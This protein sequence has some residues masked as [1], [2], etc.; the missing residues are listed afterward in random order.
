MK[1]LY[2]AS[3]YTHKSRIVQ[4]LRHKAAEHAT[5]HLFRLGYCVFSPIVH[6]HVLAAAHT[7]PGDFT[8]WQEYDQR[9]IDMMDILGVLQ[10]PGWKESK[11]VNAEIAYATLGGKMILEF[12]P[13]N[14]SIPDEL[15]SALR[16]L[17]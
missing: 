6:C 17:A 11:G 8:F 4:D 15:L 14:V 12:E 9:M 10:I 16:Q 3:P 13:A 7:M 2:L 5:A 1:T